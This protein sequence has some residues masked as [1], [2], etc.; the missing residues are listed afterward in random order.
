MG[1][2]SGQ[3]GTAIEPRQLES[4][5][6]NQIPARGE[7]KVFQLLLQSLVAIEGIFNDSSYAACGES[8]PLS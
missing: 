3:T 5:D 1:S 8:S 7:K 6:P 4:S 2:P